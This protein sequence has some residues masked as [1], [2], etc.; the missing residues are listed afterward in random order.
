MQIQNRFSEP[1]NDINF[2][3]Y[4]NKSQNTF[5]PVDKLLNIA[6]LHFNFCPGGIQEGSCVEI[7]KKKVRRGCRMRLL[8]HNVQNDYTCTLCTA[9]DSGLS[10]I[11][12]YDRC[13]CSVN[14]ALFKILLFFFYRRRTLWPV[15]FQ[16]ERVRVLSVINTDRYEYAVCLFVS[17]QRRA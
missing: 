5:R 14:F 7:K 10:R 15:Y 1:F 9:S 17:C 11:F 6:P 8:I 16:T 4:I 3:N 2:K 13:I 12:Y